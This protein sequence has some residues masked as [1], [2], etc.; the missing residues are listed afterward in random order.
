[1]IFNVDISFLLIGYQ[2]KN[3][4][5]INLFKRREIFK[6]KNNKH[7]RKKIRLFMMV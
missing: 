2:R 4:S 1:M 3:F 6:G 5:Y 7:N